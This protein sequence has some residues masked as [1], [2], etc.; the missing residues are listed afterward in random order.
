MNE[1]FSLREYV[2]VINKCYEDDNINDNDEFWKKSKILNEIFASHK[3]N[4]KPIERKDFYKFSENLLKELPENKDVAGWFL[5]ISFEPLPDFDAVL[6]T[7]RFFIDLELKHQLN[8]QSLNDIKEQFNNQN[9]VFRKIDDKKQILDL[10]FVAKENKL[11]RY[12]QEKNSYDDQYSFKRLGIDLKDCVSDE[13]NYIAQFSRSDFLISPLN[14]IH[15]FIKNEY[16]LDS[17]QK[18]VKQEILKYKKENNAGIFAVEGDAGTGKSLLAY[19]L[20]K[21]W[22]TEDI[23]FIY[24]GKLKD[25]QRNLEKYFLKLR[26]CSGK[27]LNEEVLNQYQIIIVDEAQ[28]LYHDKTLN[29]LKMWIEKNYR[30]CMIVLFFDVKQA[31]SPKDGG[32]LLHNLCKTYQK[33]GKGKWRELKAVKRSNSTISYFVKN[34]FDLGK[35]SPKWITTLN[36]KDNIDVKLFSNTKDSL[37]WIETKIKEGYIFLLPTKDRYSNSLFDEYDALDKHSENTHHMLGEE[38]SKIITVIDRS[39]KY[40]ND[41]KLTEN[42]AFSSKYYYYMA[43]ETYVNMTRAKDNLAI[44]I[45]DNFD[46][47]KAIVEII[48]GEKSRY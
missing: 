18:N 46:V 21:T 35:K 24:P 41:G 42:R 43:N 8:S 15:E 22:S 28:R 19:D 40:T 48:F 37:N 34:L 29:I 1:S 20:I 45:I 4:C 12:V 6:Y 30:T 10:V 39:L 14:N 9:R 36:Y 23:L 7:D 17:P 38:N 47:Y 3:T 26:F 44:A 13:K 27:D 32:Q 33:D 11:Y 25:K 16:F 2:A 31:L 5:G